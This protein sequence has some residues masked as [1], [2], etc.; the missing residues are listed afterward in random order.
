M[1]VKRCIF[2]RFIAALLFVGAAS[3]GGSTQP[4]APSAQERAVACWADVFEGTPDLYAVLRPQAMKRDGLYGELLKALV[5][6]ARARGVAHGDTMVRAAEGAEEII[7]GLSEGS[8]A[9]LVL[10]GVPA[11]LDPKK[12]TDAEGHALFRPM[13]DRAEVIEYELLDRRYAGAGALFVLPDRTW[14]GALGDA[15]A[16]ARQVFEV[17]VR[18]PAPEVDPEALAVVRV[19]GR[20]VHALD[21]HPLFGVLSKKLTTAVFALRPGKGGLVI[22]LTY[23]DADRAAW[24]EM[25]AKRVVE[26][27]AK[28]GG[29]PSERRAWLKRAE[30][31]YEGN[32][33]FVRV[34]IPPR[35]LEE[36]PNASGADLG[37]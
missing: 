37:L 20:L 17:P 21:R 5:R 7:V 23:A 27:L 1:F 4:P 35:L 13:N 2:A 22:G 26:E 16:R 6:A 14:I 31:T 19:S 9:A 29:G 3:C 25:Q 12:I 30:V 32:T 18:R 36:L 15:R 28:E 34:P 24:G 10:R 8:D 11:S 33:V